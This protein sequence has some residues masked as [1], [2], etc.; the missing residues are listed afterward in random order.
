MT[1]PSEG[2]FYFERGEQSEDSI[3]RVVLVE[4]PIDAMSLAVM[5]RTDSKKTL[6]LSTD[7]AGRLPFEFLQEVKEVALAFDND[8]GGEAMATRVSNKLPKAVR[9]TPKSIDWNQDLVNSFDWSKTNQ[10][11]QPGREPRLRR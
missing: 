6:Y 7:G 5:E 10:N 2:W 9:K 3:K 1:D 4:S 11:I 8:D